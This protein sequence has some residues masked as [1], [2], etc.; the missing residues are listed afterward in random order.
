[1]MNARLHWVLLILVSVCIGVTI[2]NLFPVQRNTNQTRVFTRVVFSE[3][4][5]TILVYSYRE[6]A[7]GNEILDGDW[8]EFRRD[9]TRVVEAR[10]EDG[11]AVSYRMFSKP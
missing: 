7:D 1:M 4:A 8:L 2:G 6:S 5:D 10:Y 9:G 11:T 3:E